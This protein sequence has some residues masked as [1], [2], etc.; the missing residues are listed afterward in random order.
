M[1]P[2][3]LQSL[4]DHSKELESC[5]KG[6][7]TAYL[8]AGSTQR[9][10]LPTNMDL[11]LHQSFFQRPFRWT[12]IMYNRVIKDIVRQR[13]HL[14]LECVV[15]DDKT[16]LSL[17]TD[18]QLGRVLADSR[19]KFTFQEWRKHNVDFWRIEERQCWFSKSTLS[20]NLVSAPVLDVTVDSVGL[21]GESKAC[22]FWFASKVLLCFW[23][24]N[25]WSTWKFTEVKLMWRLCDMRF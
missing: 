6:T 19:K 14:K 9:S 13:K 12:I 23:F 16:S 25:Y 17:Q 22:L 3:S 21:F 7:A 10:P 1:W 4:K 2:I 24:R 11:L 8:L 5:A 20:K 18:R 15:M